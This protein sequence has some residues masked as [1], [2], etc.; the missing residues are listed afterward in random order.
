MGLRGWRETPD[1]GRSGGAASARAAADGV[2]LHF[3]RE[4][5]EST[6][7]CDVTLTPVGSER[8]GRV[9]VLVVRAGS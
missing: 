8:S 1:E 2:T 6:S 7:H 9:R 3:V 4:T 5:G